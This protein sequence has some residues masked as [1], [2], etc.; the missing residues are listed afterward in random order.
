MRPHGNDMRMSM[1]TSTSTSTSTSGLAIGKTVIV[2]P[3]EPRPGVDLRR[4]WSSRQAGRHAARA[5]VIQPLT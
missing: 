5:V 2:A 3:A 4:Q 1:S